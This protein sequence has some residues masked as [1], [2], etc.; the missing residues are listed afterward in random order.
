MSNNLNFDGKKSELKQEDNTKKHPY[1]TQNKETYIHLE[2]L[3]Q[4]IPKIF[5]NQIELQSL[6]NA[7]ARTAAEIHLLNSAFNSYSSKKAFATGLLDLA[8]IA[9][10][11]TQMKQLII[12]RR[13]S[14]WHVVDIVL[15]FSICASLILQIL[16]GIVLIFSAK[17]EDFY[18]EET[19]VQSV[20]KNN[21][22]TLLVL[23]ITIVNIF[24]NVFLNI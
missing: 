7:N 11:F 5:P 24:V 20:K 10:N 9:T 14:P 16:C 3:D 23:A 13:S 12:A 2:N 8:L 18:H 21:T 19:R 6:L 1:M 17:S 15:M 4:K 22:I